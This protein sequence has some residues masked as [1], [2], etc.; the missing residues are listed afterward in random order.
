[1]ES[2]VFVLSENILFALLEQPNIVS[3]VYF[4][5]YAAVRRRRR[6][7]SQW[8]VNYYNRE[9]FPDLMYS[10]VSCQSL[11]DNVDNTFKRQ[12]WKRSW[13]RCLD[14]DHREFLFR[15]SY[16]IIHTNI[17]TLWRRCNENFMSARILWGINF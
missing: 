8:I 7:T 17:T 6:P 14:L 16:D 2:W 15:C 1:M 11:S 10:W 3:F 13:N 5:R 12:V 9:L 4:C